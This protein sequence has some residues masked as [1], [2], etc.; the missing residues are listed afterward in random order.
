[1]AK[2]TSVLIIEF[3]F[4]H[5]IAF[6]LFAILS[7]IIGSPFI[8]KVFKLRFIPD[9]FMT[10]IFIAGIYAI[11]H[12]KKHIYISLALAVPMFILIW[13]SRI[14]KDFELYIIG[15]VFGILF[16]GFVISLLAKFILDHE[17]ITT[18]VIFTGVVIYFFMAIFWAMV[19][20]ILDYL[21][22]G[23]FSFPESPSRSVYQYLYFSFVTITT[24]GYG[25]VVPLTQEAYSLVILEAVSGQTYLVVV[26]AWLVGM[27]V[28]RRS[29]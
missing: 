12:K 3:F 29:R 6:L 11:G 7:F 15:E 8:I 2:K 25:D 20:L 5:R 1:M 26:V 16:V 27:H 10:F 24:L 28:S 21:N 13:S 22:P 4:R 23:S 9:I 18:E 14:L 17:N 19:Y